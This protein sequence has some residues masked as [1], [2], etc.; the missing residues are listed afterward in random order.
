[1]RHSK[2]DKIVIEKIVDE[3]CDVD[4]EGPKEQSL[5][6]WFIR[7]WAREIASSCVEAYRKKQND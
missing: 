6:N 4:I 3:M 7:P 1:M 2:K 5:M